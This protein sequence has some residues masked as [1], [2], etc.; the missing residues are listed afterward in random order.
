MSVNRKVT[1]WSDAYDN[2]GHIPN[3]ADYMERWPELAADF[4]KTAKSKLDISYGSSKRNLLDLFYPQSEPRGLFVFVHGGYWLRFEK[5]FWSHL[6][7][8]LLAKGWAVAMP[9]Y[10]LC[11]D[12]NVSGITRE[13]S[14]AIDIAAQEVEGPI[15]LSGHSAG[16]H[17]VT[18][19]ICA[20]TH[21][22]PKVLD[23]IERVISI[24][25]VHDL[26][27]ILRIVQNETIR[28]DEAEAIAESPAL[29]NP[30]NDI[31]V[32]C[33]VGCDERPEFIRQNDLLANIWT[34]LG[35]ETSCHHVSGRHHFDVIDDMINPDGLIANLCR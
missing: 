20:D 13:I 21:L 35:V 19:Q 16:G 6:S 4:R 24:S 5:S 27:P 22:A 29:L 8:G 23:R 32:D 2:V 10:T 28:L 33:I 12:I 25:G 26:R 17:L 9:S 14:S 3:A 7:A 1:N 30:L 11:P 18:R 31:P 34:G 15:V